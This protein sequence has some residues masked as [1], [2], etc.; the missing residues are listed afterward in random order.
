MQAVIKERVI[1]T[2]TKAA[3]ARPKN[4]TEYLAS[5]PRLTHGCKLEVWFENKNR[6]TQNV[7]L[8][9]LGRV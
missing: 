2:G 9:L 1:L 4:R 7:T 8:N 6:K 3:S 5:K